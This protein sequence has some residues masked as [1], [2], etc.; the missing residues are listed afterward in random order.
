MDT[1]IFFTLI[2]FTLIRLVLPFI[3]LIAIGTWL[4]RRS[5]QH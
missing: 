5:H 3:V 2:L 1:T 4:N